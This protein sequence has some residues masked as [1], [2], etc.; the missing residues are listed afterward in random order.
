MVFVLDRNPS[1]IKVVAEVYVMAK[2]RYCIWHLSHNV[3]LHV[4]QGRDEVALQFR[5]LHKF[6]QSLSLNSNI[7]SLGRYPLCAIY[8]DKSV[9][10]KNWAKFHFSGARYSI[11]TFNCAESLNALLENA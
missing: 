4:K 6:I 7:K 2:H 11:D 3:K 9:D 1:L 8:L 5:K 10:V